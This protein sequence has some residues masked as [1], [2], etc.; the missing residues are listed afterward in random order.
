MNTFVAM[1]PAGLVGFTL[2]RFITGL[3]KE[4]PRYDVR[5]LCNAMLCALASVSASAGIIK[6]W[7]ALVI[8]GLAGC[9][10]C[11]FCLVF[12]RIKW[13]DPLE[14]F[15]V[16]G[17]GGLWGSIAGPLFNYQHGLVSGLKSSGKLFGYE[18]IAMVAVAAISALC[19]WIY[20]FVWHKLDAAR[21]SK[22]EEI[23][24]MDAIEAAHAKQVDLKPLME[25]IDKLY[26]DNPRK[27]C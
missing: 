26:P 1:C 15:Q 23:I 20:F 11:V 25:A 5:S 27:G 13:E 24:G 21:L 18:L 22:A 10:Y 14:S 7:A 19:S 4:L 16:Y 2:K 12:H 9:W 6:P 8:G 17:I 3:N